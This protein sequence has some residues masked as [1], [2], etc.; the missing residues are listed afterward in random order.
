MDLARGFVMVL[1]ALDHSKYY[2]NAESTDASEM[3]GGQFPKF[4]SPAP[5]FLRFLTLLCAPMFVFLMT[6][7][8]VLFFSNR[9]NAGWT[10]QKIVRYFVIRGTL[11]IFLQFVL[12]NPIWNI[13]MP[14]GLLPVYFG[15]LY[16]LGLMMICCSLILKV[17]SVY[18][19]LLT[20]VVILSTPLI[21]PHRITV[22]RRS[23]LFQESWRFPVQLS[24]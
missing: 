20:A 13:G 24:V 3:W 2:F 9:S 18:V 8:M 22:Q 15:V 4:D 1:M 11:L 12:E 17:P 5:F 7:S 19:G 16:M 23:E 6:T 21:V 14:S 10:Q